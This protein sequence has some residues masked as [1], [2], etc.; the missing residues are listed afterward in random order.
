MSSR[1]SWQPRQVIEPR[2]LHMSRFFWRDV[3]RMQTFSMLKLLGYVH[4]QLLAKRKREFTV[5]EP[6]STAI[7]ESFLS[8]AEDSKSVEQLHTEAIQILIRHVHL[9]LKTTRQRHDMAIHYMHMSTFDLTMSLFKHRK[10][11]EATQQR[12]VKLPAN[13]NLAALNVRWRLECILIM[14]H[15]GFSLMVLSCALIGIA[16]FVGK[17]C[18]AA[19][20]LTEQ[21]KDTMTSLF[22]L[23][24]TFVFLNQLM[25]VISTKELLMERVLT[26]LFGG[27]DAHISAEEGFVMS[28]Y[29]ANLARKIWK[30]TYLSRSDR[31]TVMLLAGGDLLQGLVVEEDVQAKSAVILGVKQF[32]RETGYHKS[33]KLVNWVRTG[34]HV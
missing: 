24:L 20:L 23:V 19:V 22:T 31:W 11:L 18:F 9:D 34:H 1:P 29:L 16:S 4:P 6:A 30:S 32:M 17:L 2:Y 25:G 3:P 28:A 12:H 27:T 15:V 21:G 33:S 5:R 7:L 26:F 13:V 14:E 10:A 8:R